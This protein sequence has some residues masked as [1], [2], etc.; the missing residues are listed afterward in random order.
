MAQLDDMSVALRSADRDAEGQTGPAVPLVLPSTLVARTDAIISG[1][2]CVP[3][4]SIAGRDAFTAHALMSRLTEARQRSGVLPPA[5]FNGVILVDHRLWY[6]LHSLGFTP[7]EQCRIQHPNPCIEA[8]GAGDHWA[9]ELALGHAIRLDASLAGPDYS[10]S[11]DACLA[12][13]GCVRNGIWPIPHLPA[14]SGMARRDAGQAGP[15]RL[16]PCRVPRGPIACP[17]RW[18]LSGPVTVGV[19]S[20]R[21][22]GHGRRG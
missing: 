2:E 11:K 20:R 16:C 4:V 13:R 3:A 6:A 15:A 17:A 10:F 5:A 8:T 1:I 22:P 18:S 12:H 7:A 9:M 21:A 19:L 14:R